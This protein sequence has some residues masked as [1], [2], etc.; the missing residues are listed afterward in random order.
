MCD[1]QPAD[2]HHHARRAER[3]RD[4]FGARRPAR[5]AHQKAARPMDSPVSREHCGDEWDW[6][7]LPVRSPVA[8]PRGRRHLAAGAG[9]GDRRALWL[10]PQRRLGSPLRHHRTGSPVSQRLRPRCAALPEG[11]DLKRAGADAI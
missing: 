10:S 8:V 2:V 1:L 3:S 9:R 6:L 11:A 4:R 7:R 5:A